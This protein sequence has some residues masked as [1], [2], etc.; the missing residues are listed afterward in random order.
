MSTEE[1]K[2]LL[3]LAEEDNHIKMRELSQAV[4]S[5]PSIRTVQRL[6][7][8]LHMKKW[9]QCEGLRARKSHL[10]MQKRGE[11]GQ[12]LMLI[13]QERTSFGLSGQMNALLSVE[14]VLDQSILLNPPN[15]RLSSEIS[16]SFIVGKG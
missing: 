1:Q 7:Q 10:R 12:R 14:L 8:T 5:S 11:N 13:I 3:D 6:F 2:R 15:G 9:K 4:Q 16:M